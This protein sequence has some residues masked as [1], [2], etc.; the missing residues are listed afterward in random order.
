MPKYSAGLLLYRFVAFPR[1]LF[2]IEYVLL[3]LL[4]LGARFSTRLFHE[5]GREP[6]GASARRYGIIGAGDDGE[7]VLREL[8]AGGPSTT[9]ACFIDDDARR[10]NAAR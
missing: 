6:E 7:R 1:T 8:R 10:Q 4:V 3:I 5:M 9:V 2:V